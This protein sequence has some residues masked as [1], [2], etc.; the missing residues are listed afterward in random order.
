MWVYVVLILQNIESAIYW[1]TQIVETSISQSKITALD[2][3]SFFIQYIVL[4]T[5][6]HLF[7]DRRNNCMCQPSENYYIIK[8]TNKVR[9][10]IEMCKS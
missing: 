3:I 4:K 10:S 8:S 7:R 5:L 6:L 2:S 9:I 1:K